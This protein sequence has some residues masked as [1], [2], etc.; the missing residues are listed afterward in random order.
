M[1]AP[2]AVS[3]AAPTELTDLFTSGGVVFYDAPVFGETEPATYAGVV[4]GHDGTHVRVCTLGLAEQSAA[5]P[6]DALR[7]NA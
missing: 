1:T 2:K 6:A 7:L 4:I 5:F 3:E